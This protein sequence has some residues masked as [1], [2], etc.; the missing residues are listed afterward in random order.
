METPEQALGKTIDREGK[1]GKVVGVIK[2]FNMTTLTTPISSLV[3]EIEPNA[4]TTLN[5]RFKNS[6]VTATIENIRKEWNLMFP[7]KSFQFN[8]LDEQLDGQYAN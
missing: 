6:N 4:W 5:I 3:M 2:D 1:L 7:E 8:F